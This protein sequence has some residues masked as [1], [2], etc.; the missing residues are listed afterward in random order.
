MDN[1]NSQWTLDR[2]LIENAVPQLLVEQAIYDRRFPYRS[3]RVDRF[4]GSSFVIYKDENIIYCITNA[5]VVE[6]ALTIEVRF[7]FLGKFPIKAILKS[8]CF[9]RDLAL[10]EIT[11]NTAGEHWYAIQDTVVPLK[12]DDSLLVKQQDKVYVAGYPL[13]EENLQI[14]SGDVSGFSV[15]EDIDFNF[16]PQSYIQITAPVNPGN[17]GG[18]TLNLKGNVIGINSAGI[19]SASN[20][21]YSIPSRNVYAMLDQLFVDF[22]LQQPAF[23]IKTNSNHNGLYINKI[24]PNS[25]FYYD[26]NYNDDLEH[27]KISLLKNYYK[28]QNQELQYEN[29]SEKLQKGD[30]LTEITVINNNEVYNFKLD[31]YGLSRLQNY[32][33]R[34]FNI[35]DIEEFTTYGSLVTFKVYREDKVLDIQEHYL[36]RPIFQ[37]MIRPIF[38]LYEH[39]RYDYILLGGMILME[40]QPLLS[41]CIEERERF[42]RKIYVV[43]IFKGTEIDSFHAV[44]E[45]DKLQKINNQYIFCLSDIKNIVTNTKDEKLILDFENN[46]HLDLDYKKIIDE[47]QKTIIKYKIPCVL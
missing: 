12:F 16:G 28:L 44:R 2:R 31:R 5:H 22:F 8:Y 24:Y 23:A 47:D 18:P 7:P 42:L 11:R 25:I 9:F 4:T 34:T 37:F 13:G 30:I 27:R 17:S 10:I 21:G 6:N 20:I 15:S 19:T 41:S 39:E 32:K 14:G 38:P 43:T 36:P 29:F 35:D 45:N 40:N 33:W 3:P 46:V 26:I 1:M